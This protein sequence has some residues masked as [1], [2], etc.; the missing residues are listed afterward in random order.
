[1]AYDRMPS[2]SSMHGTRS[3]GYGDLA[4]QII[5]LF[6]A[7]HGFSAEQMGMTFLGI[8]VGWSARCLVCRFKTGASLSLS[9]L[10]FIA[11]YS[12]WSAG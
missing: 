12:A 4:F 6:S 2:T 1:M 5:L 8:K 7:K 9:S 10:F 3:P 11:Y